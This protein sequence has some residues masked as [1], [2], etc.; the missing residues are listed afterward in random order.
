MDSPV[1]Y[2]ASHQEVKLSRTQIGRIRSFIE[3]GGLLYTQSDG[4]NIAFDVSLQKLVRELFPAY[5]LA[6]VPADHPIYSMLYTL[7]PRPALKMVSNGV[8]ALMIHSS[9][10]LAMHWQQRA[11]KT[12]TASFQFGVNLFLYAA[13]KSDWRNRLVTLV[14]SEPAA[15]HGGT[16]RVARLKDKG[17]WNPEPAAWPRYARWFAAARRTAVLNWRK[18]RWRS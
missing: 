2:L 13:G 5:R 7:E 11:T 16:I 9:A 15:V 10:D 18:W 17:A 8:R 1:L 3:A 12:H 14:I 6:D 4:G